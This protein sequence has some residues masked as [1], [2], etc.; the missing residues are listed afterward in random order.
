MRPRARGGK[1]PFDWARVHSRL[2]AAEPS[3]DRERRDAER[4]LAVRAVRLAQVSEAPVVDDSLL[5]VISFEHA[6]RRYAIESRCVLE[7]T[8]CG[9][10]TRVPGARPTLLGMTNLR[11]ELLPVFELASAK[12]VPRPGSARLLVLGRH[13]PELAF[14]V[15]AVH[16]VSALSSRSL[17][18]P[19]TLGADEQ[20]A[21][22][23]GISET[24]C[25]LLDGDALLLDRHVFV[26]KIPAGAVPG[27]DATREDR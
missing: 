3:E 15:D 11:G 16:E 10:L 27:R 1:Q 5:E 4:V 25:A 7:V 24:G 21:Y 18:E 13:A 26:A 20:V 19:R 6:G 22:V 2:A 17:T 12:A 8:T 23:R 9:P 14:L